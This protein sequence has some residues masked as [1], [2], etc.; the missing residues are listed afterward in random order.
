MLE[1]SA[2]NSIFFLHLVIL[3]KSPPVVQSINSSMNNRRKQR[4]NVTKPEETQPDWES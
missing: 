2:T 1:Y 4:E 3:K